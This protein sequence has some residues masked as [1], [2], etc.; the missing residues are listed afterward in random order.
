M[1]SNHFAEKEDHDFDI[2]KEFFKY[3]FYWKY[4][5]L[6]IVLCLVTAFLYIRYTDRI[7]ETTAKI[8]ILDK[9]DSALEMPTAEDLFSASKINLENEKEL[10]ISYPIIKKVVEKLKKDVADPYFE[11][12]IKKES[13]ELA[14]NFERKSV[15]KFLV[16]GQEPSS[17][18][19]A[20]WSAI[21]DAELKK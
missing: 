7:Y 11:E 19:V 6:S 17:R 21:I 13:L 18:S 2:K 12:L 15:P 9:K 14:Q 20:A 10:I 8:K 1:D 5:L 3:F 16:A 4:F